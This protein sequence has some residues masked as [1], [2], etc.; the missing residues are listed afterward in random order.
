MSNATPTHAETSA[1]PG[2]I[3]EMTAFRLYTAWSS[4]NPIF[5]RLCEGQYN[6]TRR[7]WRLLATVVNHARLTSSQLA[8]EAGLDA[9]RTSR[10]ITALCTKGWL[11][12]ERAP[13]DGR[14]VHVAATPAGRTLYETMMPAIM[15]LNQLI[16]QD[17]SRAEVETLHALLERVG[18]R[19]RQLYGND[20]VPARANRGRARARRDRPE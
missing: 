5:T 1:L 6:I 18:E 2:T 13:H 9:V 16:T 15:E 3:R 17:L 14:T 19:A 20:L 8:A 10:A 12:R 7:E 11:Q 4:A